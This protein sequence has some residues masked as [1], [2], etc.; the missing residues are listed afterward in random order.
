MLNEVEVKVKVGA[1]D[2]SDFLP[3]VSTFIIPP[4]DLTSNVDRRWRGC[5]KEFHRCFKI[6]LLLLFY[7][8][9]RF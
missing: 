3:R 9:H 1:A 4:S 6:L 2:N 5:R 7:W 8:F